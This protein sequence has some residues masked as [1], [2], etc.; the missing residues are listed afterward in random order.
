MDVG[1]GRGLHLSFFVFHFSLSSFVAFMLD[2]WQGWSR[3]TH[4]I[5]LGLGKYVL[6]A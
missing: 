4:T 5:A 1:E 2:N 3:H 6:N